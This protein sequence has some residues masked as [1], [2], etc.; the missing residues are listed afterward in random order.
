MYRALLLALCLSSVPAVAQNDA[1]FPEPTQNPSATFRVFRTQN[2][3]TLLK[4]DTRGV[5]G[6]FCT[7]GS[8]T[9]WY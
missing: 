2:I 1:P 6:K 3:Y 8:E 9:N 7:S 4:L 5:P